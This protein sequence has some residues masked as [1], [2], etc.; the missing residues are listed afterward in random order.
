MRSQC[1]PTGAFGA[2]AILMLNAPLPASPSFKAQML[3]AREDAIAQTVCRLLS[4]KGFDAMTVDEV[5]AA[6]GMAKASLY[7][8]FASKEDLAAAAMVGVL[9][10][11]AA[12]LA[13]QPAGLGGLERLQAMLRWAI[14]LQLA[15]EMPP[16]PGPNS[17]LRAALAAHPG[18]R[19][20][21]DGVSRPLADCIA[22]AQAGGDLPV[23]W[24]AQAVLYTLYARACDP[25]PGLLKE[26]GRYGD[27]EIVDL[28]LAAC[29]DG[30][31]AR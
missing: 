14:E 4:D 6:V 21:L 19:D 24:P 7:K 20:A 17:C 2:P 8:L 11:A 25:L 5:A 12:F 1:V 9:Q 30:L 28:A 13:T 15:G 31:R 22:Q 10:R 18:Y 3:R 26:S 23:A 16:L 29:F 27:A